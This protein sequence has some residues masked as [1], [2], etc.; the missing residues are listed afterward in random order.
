M[1]REGRTITSRKRKWT[2]MGRETTFKRLWNINLTGRDMTSVMRSG[3]RVSRK[4]VAG[5]VFKSATQDN[6]TI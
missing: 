5:G 6:G 4:H 2:W 1:G 3:W